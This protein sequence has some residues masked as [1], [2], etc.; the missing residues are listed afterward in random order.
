ML[1]D[2]FLEYLKSER[3]RSERTV[4]NYRLA[5]REF[6]DFF[7]SQEGGDDVK[8]AR[9]LRPGRHTCYNGRHRGKPPRE[10]ARI[11]KVGHSPHSNSIIIKYLV[12]FIIAKIFIFGQNI[13]QPFN[14]SFHVNANSRA[15]SSVGVTTS[16]EVLVGQFMHRKRSLRSE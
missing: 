5:L 9:P 10:G 1:E 6:K 15:S 2:S 12:L 11:P 7:N 13:L 14:G 16:L 4:S 3:N 8:S